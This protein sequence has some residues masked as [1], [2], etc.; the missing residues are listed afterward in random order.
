MKNLLNRKKT[1]FSSSHWI[2]NKVLH[3]TSY[4]IFLTFWSPSVL[5]KI[6][7]HIKSTL[8]IYNLSMLKKWISVVPCFGFFTY[9]RAIENVK[10]F[11]SVWF[12]DHGLLVKNDQR[13]KTFQMIYSIT[14]FRK[15]IFFPTYQLW[16]HNILY[17]TCTPF[18]LHFEAIV[19]Y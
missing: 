18:S 3:L 1:M 7:Q 17:L 5:L 8:L 15:K 14:M 13:W 4:F 19:F 11:F 9:H 12:S 10:Y 16:H 2:C 6:Y